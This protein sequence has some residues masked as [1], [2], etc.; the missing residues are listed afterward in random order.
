MRRQY[1]G[2]LMRYCS[3]GY[4]FGKVSVPFLALAP[5]PV[6]SGS[7]QYLAQLFIKPKNCTKSCLFNAESIIISQK[8]GISFLIFR[9]LSKS[10]SGTRTGLHSG[11]CSAKGKSCSSGS[12]T[13]QCRSMRIRIHNTENL[14]GFFSYKS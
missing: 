13:L 12:T 4:D 8:V 2:T 5:A 14:N 9:L 6:G 10:I 11:S 3:S 1:F 7:R